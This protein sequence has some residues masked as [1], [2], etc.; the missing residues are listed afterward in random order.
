[1]KR[2]FLFLCICLPMISI[3]VMA[4]DECDQSLKDAKALY[5]A[6]KYKKAKEIFVYV[7][8]ICNPTYGSA[9]T[10]VKKCDEAMNGGPKPASSSK[11][12]Q[13]SSPATTLSASKT[14]VNVSEGT[15]SEF[16]AIS[17]N[18]SWSISRYP[19][20]WCQVSKSNT[21]ITLTISS[22]TN[23]SSRSTSL[24]IT[25][26]DNKNN[27]TINVTQATTKSSKSTAAYLSLS[28]TSISS[29]S[30]GTTEYITV[31]TNT[32]WEIEYPSASMYSVT[33]YSNN[34]IK[35]VINKNTTS[36][37]RSDYFNIKTTD[38]KQKVKVSLSQ[39]AGSS[40]SSS[41]SSS[42][43]NSSSSSSGSGYTALRSFNYYHGK[44]E[45]DWFGI[46]M[47]LGTGIEN[48][49]S[50]FAFRYSVLKI[51]PFVIGL[52][53]D[54][55]RNYSGFYYQ[56]DIKLVFPWD[57][58]CAVEFGIGPSI[59]V[60]IGGSSYSSYPTVFMTTELGILYH[61]GD[62]CSSD[63]FMRYDGIFSF[64]VSINFSTGF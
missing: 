32:A 58:D 40:S 4:D 35:V 6:G 63:F 1:M 47:G 23:T 3:P 57:S 64:G 14:Q 52:K 5:N 54:F 33:K 61:W 30:Y 19:D 16:I 56:P 43:Y 21:G 42:N 8:Q 2:F 26:S 34:S 53:Y 17:S 62:V 55:I 37:S 44:W 18:K 25:T 31:N 59:N 39:T 41:Y 12:Q 24:Q 38:G 36:S 13:S 10:W 60:D 27:V 11:P 51:E 50:F 45:I 49:Y 22:N 28:K 15:T 46:R 7:Q 48:D 20:S 9:D 29:S